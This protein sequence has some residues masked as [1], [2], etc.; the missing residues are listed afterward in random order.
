VNEMDTD[1]LKANARKLDIDLAPEVTSEESAYFRYYGIDFEDQLDRVTHYFGYIEHNELKIASHYFKNQGAERTCFVVH[2]YLDH[3]GLYRPMINYLLHRGCNVVIFDLPGHGLS[4]GERASI[5]SF[6][7]Y[8]LVLRRCLEFFYKKVES[9]WHVVAQSMGGAIVM[10][11]LLSQQ[12]D[13]ESGPFERVLLLAPLVRPSNWF[14]VRLLRVLLKPFRSRVKR[15]FTDN[16]H[17]AEFVKHVK[18][19]PLA[20][21]YIPVAWVTAL[22]HWVKRFHRLSWSQNE[23]LVVQGTGDRTVDWKYNLKAIANKFPRAKLMQVKDAKHHLIGEEDAYFERV[24]Q[25]A[26]LYFERRKKT[27]S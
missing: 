27:R 15:S 4:S 11:Y 1:A 21:R 17:D 14:G 13:E 2:G 10:D 9:P 6:G 25:A 23:V 3:S 24:T 22:R 19:D 26:D 16:S 5:D 18:S 8:V 12:V 20:P 7:E